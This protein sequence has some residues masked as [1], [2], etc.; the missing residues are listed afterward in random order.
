MSFG[1]NLK[2]DILV[3]KMKGIYMDYST[4]KIFTND[5]W[6][7]YLPLDVLE[8]IAW[9]LFAGYYN[10]IQKP[11]MLDYHY[12][13]RNGLDKNCPTFILHNG[14]GPNRQDG[15]GIE[16]IGKEHELYELTKY[17][18][19]HSI[20]HLGT[21]TPE[22]MI[23]YNGEFYKKEGHEWN[24]YD[25][26]KAICPCIKKEFIKFMDMRKEV[27]NHLEK[28]EGFSPVLRWYPVING[29]HYATE[30]EQWGWKGCQCKDKMIMSPYHKNLFT[31]MYSKKNK[32][33]DFV[34]YIQKAKQHISEYC[35]DGYEAWFNEGYKNWWEPEP[36][37]I[38]APMNA[39]YLHNDKT[40][41]LIK[42]FNNISYKKDYK[43]RTDPAC[44]AMLPV[45]YSMPTCCGKMAKG[46][47]CA[48]GQNSVKHIAFDLDDLGNYAGML[49][50]FYAAYNQQTSL[51]MTEGKREITIPM[52]KKCCKIY[53]EVGIGSHLIPYTIQI[54]VWH[55]NG[56]INSDSSNTYN[57][58]YLN[59]AKLAADYGYYLT[60]YGY[61][62][63]NGKPL[64]VICD[65]HKSLKKTFAAQEWIADLP[66]RVMP[67]KQRLYIRR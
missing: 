39:W 58:G 65:N 7:N 5:C 67:K 43:L 66:Q 17:Y 20:A 45:W 9:Y 16:P 1:H 29:N 62:I 15:A 63:Y 47:C 25:Y 6:L 60:E 51:N 2:K 57:Q 24:C 48:T 4:K 22:G 38:K 27:K 46:N 42:G 59:I 14:K 19:R 49:R 28:P 18:K 44:N 13:S 41:N 32:E 53:I 11:F 54:S 35:K 40:S 26:R 10:N 34:K 12:K 37:Y 3:D 23:K 36:I 52:C 21:A 56:M 50:P 55:M 30:Q 8:H 64:E 31:I 61:L 33:P